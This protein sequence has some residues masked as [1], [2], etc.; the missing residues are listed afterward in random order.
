MGHVLEEVPH[1]RILAII[2]L[3]Q[4][5]DLPQLVEFGPIHCRR[6]Y[7]GKRA[8]NILPDRRRRV[9]WLVRC[10][11]KWSKWP[12]RWTTIIRMNHIAVDNKEVRFQRGH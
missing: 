3:M 11:S 7:G 8:W 6:E 4:A 10:R 1:G 5:I 2:L 9:V 12:F